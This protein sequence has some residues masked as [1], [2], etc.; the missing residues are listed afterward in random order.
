MANLVVD[1]A[2]SVK[3]KPGSSLFDIFDRQYYDQEFYEEILKGQGPKFREFKLS[4]GV[5]YQ[6]KESTGVITFLGSYG[7]VRVL[8]DEPLDVEALR[9]IVPITKVN[10]DAKRTRNI[11]TSTSN[12]LEAQQENKTR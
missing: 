12:I 1:G 4:E 2:G 6:Y 10:S 11:N 8:Y 5:H 9:R 3:L 7:E